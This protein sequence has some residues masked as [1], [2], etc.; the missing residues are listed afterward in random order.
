MGPLRRFGRVFRLGEFRGKRRDEVREEIDFYIA[1]RAKELM[2]QGLEES[3]AMKRAEE[4]FG[5]RDRIERETLRWS[6]KTGGRGRMAV[7][8]GMR[9][10]GQVA[11]GLAR[12]PA[13]TTTVLITLGLGVGGSAAMFTVVN[14]VLLRPLP[15]PDPDALVSISETNSR[16]TDRSSAPLN[17]LDLREGSSTLSHV[18]AYRVRARN[19]LGEG[20]PERLVAGNVSA[21]FFATF[22]VEALVGRTFDEAAARPGDTRSVVLSHDLWV[23]R[24]GSD[25]SVVG[26][27]LRLDRESVAVR[28]V[29]PPGFK[30]PGDADLWI[31]AWGDVPDLGVTPSEDHLQ[32]RDAWYFQT[33][34]RLA[35]G[36]ALVQAQS[37]ADGIAA[38]IREI[39]PESNAETGFLLTPL[40][41]ATVSSAR[42]SLL[43]LLGAVGLVFVIACINVANLVLVRSL[44]RQTEMGVRMALG[45]GRGGLVRHVLGES[46]LL[47]LGGAVLGTVFAAGALR[48]VRRAAGEWLPRAGEVVLD[49]QALVLSAFIAL[50][51]ASAVA[52]LPVLSTRGTSGAEALKSRGAGDGTAGSQ[53]LRAALVVGES[54]LAIVLVLTAGLALKSVWGVN[55]VDLGFDSEELAFLPFTLPGASEMAEDEWRSVYRQV[56]DRVQALP[57][58][59]GAAV[60]SRGPLSTGWQAGLRVQGRE[61]DSNNPPIVGWQVVSE[62]YF[63]TLEVP[64]VAGRGFEPSDGPGSVD[65]A[66]VNQTMASTLWPDEDPLGQQINT[67]LDGQGVW[68]TVVGVAA[69]T[70]NRGP[71]SPVYPAYYRPLSQP[72]G[73]G[74]DGMVLLTR[75]SGGVASAVPQ[76]QSAAWSVN[77]DLPFYRVR[78][79]EDAAVGFSSQPRFLLAI[80]GA[81]AAVAILLGAVGIHG[82]TAFSVERRTRELGIRLA[83]GAERGRVLYEVL[84]RTLALV[85]LGLALGLMAA[86]AAGRAVSGLLYEVSPTDPGTYGAVTALFLVVAV[87]AAL[88]PAARAARVDP[89]MAMRAE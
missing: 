36:V 30:V 46:L 68:V 13:F 77:Q 54:A 61:Y 41:E 66:V 26:R 5:D 42:T 58:V 7:F 15:Y 22:G 83:L 43:L 60:A 9:R 53:R 18:A 55:R 37:E 29:M 72:G 1:M 47:G 31:K 17:Y 10:M 79:G 88:I 39:S 89:A 4:V 35:P 14:S 59:E 44:T 57:G 19:L 69:D 84:G 70:R 32:M 24:F 20:E 74:G 50:L 52:V 63:E 56:L 65:V 48:L 78:I 8:D 85:G 76:I 62:D 6:P 33:V 81:F 51:A 28:G 27:T 11:R 67:G 23:R 87:L 21:N 71:M 34:G 12:R 80:L 38:R 2:A 49:G 45:A 86:V 64:V 75:G 73:F 40:H 16:T 25:P 82:V 3:E